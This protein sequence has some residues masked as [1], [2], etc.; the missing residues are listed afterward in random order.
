MRSGLL[1]LAALCLAM[2]ALALCGCSICRPP[3]ATPDMP[4]GV[5]SAAFIDPKES[6]WTFRLEPGAVEA[7][8]ICADVLHLVVGATTSGGG[9]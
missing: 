3:E 8:R 7:M 6:C 2:L 1:A 5:E 4:P 9:E